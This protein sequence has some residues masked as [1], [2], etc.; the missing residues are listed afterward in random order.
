[1]LEK[2]KLR[3]CSFGRRKRSREAHNLP[4]GSKRNTTGR[5]G[6]RAA[7]LNEAQKA[8]LCKKKLL[9][10]GFLPTSCGSAMIPDK[11]GSAE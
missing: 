4:M 9:V 2:S 1:M 3:A 7:F 8:K 6:G 10:V 11:S 5:E